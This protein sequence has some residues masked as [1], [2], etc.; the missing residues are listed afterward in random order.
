MASKPVKVSQLNGYI[1]RVLQTDPLLGNVSVIGE[2]S[3]LKYH[4]SGHVYFSLKDE[5]S[6]I[7]CFLHAANLSRIRYELN[8][9]MEIIAHGYISVYQAGGSYS[10][11]IRD[12]EVS[13]TGDLAIAF[14]KL[15]QKLE[16]EGIFDEDHKKELPPFPK[17]IAVV[18][19]ETGA[20]VRDIIK[21]IKSRNDVTSVLVYPVLVQG[22]DA[23]ADISN[24]IKDINR[25]DDIDIIIAGRGGGSME[26]LW[27][28]N[29]ATVVH[30]IVNCPVPVVS[31]VGHEV[32]VTLSDLAADVRAATPSA[33]AE[34]VAADR[35]ALIRQ[36]TKRADALRTGM[37]R[38]LLLMRGRVA[39]QE[40]R[41]SRGR[42]DVRLAEARGRIAEAAKGLTLAVRSM[43]ALKKEQVSA[44]V[45]RL[46]ALGPRQALERGYALALSGGK[47]ALGIGDLKD[48]ALLLMRDGY[49]EAVITDRKEG[50][51][52]ERYGIWRDELRG[53]AERP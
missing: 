44:S 22:P 27:A 13:G 33:A 16:K 26:D 11:N 47:A 38:C 45:K 51:P 34:L 7:R 23:A 10:L 52:F 3:N 37:S 32:D 42:P 15:K 40:K 53:E 28:F 43:T 14:E 41:L 29:E 49:A 19:S 2:I 5:A 46:E 36:V 50:D 25:M 18:T 24:A 8:E 39:E 30:A 20:A 9:G 21:I 48:R 6:T 17:K 4:G 12:I 31:A 1:S 35:D